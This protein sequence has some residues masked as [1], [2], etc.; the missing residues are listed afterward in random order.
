MNRWDS[1]LFTVLYDDP[2]PPYEQIWNAL[3]ETDGQTKIVRP[4]Q[5]TVLVSLL[6]MM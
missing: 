2:H 1:P 5:A 3:I 6:F 4:N